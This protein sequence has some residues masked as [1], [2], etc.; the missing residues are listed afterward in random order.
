LPASSSPHST[1][2]KRGDL[3]SAATP[4]SPKS[5]GR[6]SGKLRWTICTLLFLATLINYLDR[7]TFAVATPQIA[8]EFTLSNENVAFINN[9]FTA[10]YTIGQLLTGRI[11]DLVG[12]RTGFVLIMV[13]W[14]AAGML[15]ALARGAMSL[16]VFRFVLGLGEA[17]NWPVSVKAVSEWF[18]TRERGLAVAY[19]SGGS[20]VGATLAPL[21]IAQLII[22]AGWRSAFVVIGLT[23]FLW[24]P[25]W[26]WLYRSPRSHWLI[27]R[28][29]LRLIEEDQARAGTSTGRTVGQML[30]EW[31]G[32][33]KY[34]QIW[35]LFLVR[36]FSDAILWFYIQ[37]LPKYFADERGYSIEDIRNRLWLVFL[38]AVFAGLLGGAASGRLIRKGWEV[39]RARKTVMLVTGLLMVSSIGVGMVES[40]IVALVLSSIALLAFYGYSVNTLTLPT[41]L[42]PSRLVASVSGLSGAGAG[43]G[44]MIFTYVVGQLA[45]KQSFVPVF[46]LVGVLPILSL[47]MLFFVM[48][49]VEKVVA[50]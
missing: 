44:S 14:S 42:A 48:G 28:D 12:T 21:I 50:D 39:G 18:P 7:Q 23:G 2:P 35:G 19:F 20:G 36:F 5:A 8:A 13:V 22:W 41:D 16:S 3:T 1:P 34:R 9:C 10:A 24:I 17:G 26:L 11:I 4:S 30:S 33:L 31:V 49:K 25:L 40:D 6:T 38:P 47:A 45:D 15:C 43:I 32:L 27:T 29:E 46:V 37:W